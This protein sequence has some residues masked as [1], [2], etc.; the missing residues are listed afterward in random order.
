M[1][2]EMSTSS[3][4]RVSFQVPSNQKEVLPNKRP[5]RAANHGSVTPE[6]V[7]FGK[8]GLRA[9]VSDGVS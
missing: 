9:T 1:N 2:K 5:L 7:P 8:L 6:T 3:L 4:N